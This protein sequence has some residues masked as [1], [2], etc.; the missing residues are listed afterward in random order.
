VESGYPPALECIQ[1]AAT[2]EDNLKTVKMLHENN[3]NIGFSFMFGFPYDLPRERLE[4]EHETELIETMKTIAEFSDNFLEGDYYLLFLFTPYPGVQLFP[5]YKELGYIPPDS[6]EGWS[7]V[8]LNEA[9][10]CPWVTKR[11][12]RLYRHCLKSNWF[13]MHKL[14]EVIFRRSKRLLLRKCAGYCCERARGILKE[15]INRGNLSLPLF[16]R[17]I[18][19]YF[20]GKGFILKLAHKVYKRLCK[21]TALEG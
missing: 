13:F 15:R 19:F 17:F 2:V 10:S 18:R 11:L 16:F 1:K 3:I 12:L 7:K 8:N 21:R 4:K 14:E 20:L 6:F 9:D 5:R